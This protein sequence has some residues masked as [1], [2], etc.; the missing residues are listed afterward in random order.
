MPGAPLFLLADWA[1]LL[2]GV[3]TPGDQLDALRRVELKARADI[4]V[5]LDRL[6]DEFDISGHEVDEAMVQVADALGEIEG[7][8]AYDIEQA[9]Q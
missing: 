3:R 8:L 7:D 5:A 2:T 4:R 6:A 9:N 1:R